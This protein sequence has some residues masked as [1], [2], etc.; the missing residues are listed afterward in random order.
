MSASL[1][2][3]VKARARELGPV[4]VGIC[5]S[6]SL[7]GNHDS[8][9]R[10]LPGHRS[11][12]VVLFP[13]SE[14]ALSSADLEE[15]KYD[16]L[17][18]YHEAGRVSQYLARYLEAE[19]YASAAVPAFLP[20]DMSDEKMGMVGAVDLRRAAVESGL[21]GWG[22]NGL[23]VNAR[24]GPRLRLGG[25]VTAAE[26][27]PDKRLA[28]SPCVEKCRLCLD[29]CPP[30]A[31]LGDGKIDRK[32]CGEEL[33][34]YGLRAFTRLLRDVATVRN[35]EEARELLYTQRT[36]EIW[37]ALESGSYYHC[38]TCQS[39]CPVGKRFSTAEGRSSR[40]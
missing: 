20:L 37:Q 27:E 24:V 21:G 33:F 34:T 31:L 15:K 12:V 22:K 10:I 29:A 18:C 35:E 1:S 5:A 6:G 39:V 17:F 26:L 38:W 28:S 8:L 14:A 16:T 2:Q 36:R 40:G 30:H 19:G 23:L 32:L 3:R 13:H 11:V 25:L 4:E 7:T 9:D